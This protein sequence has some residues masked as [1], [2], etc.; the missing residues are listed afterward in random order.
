M[1]HRSSALLTSVFCTSTI[2]PEDA[3]TRDSSST[4]RIA[5]KNF[6]AASAVLL[7]DLDAHQA[8]LKEIVDQILVED[9]LFVHLL[10]QRT[11]L[12]IGELADVVAEKN[13]VFGE[14]GERRG[15]CGL[16][17]FRA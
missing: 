1:P 8:E 6:A 14:R 3:S 12:L 10:D 16:Q 13:F 4:A 11:D 17:W 2:T 7:G 15:Q 5:S 9:A